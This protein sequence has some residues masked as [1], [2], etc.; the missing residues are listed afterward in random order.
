[1]NT[2]A[3]VF[4][5]AVGLAY[6]QPFGLYI[7]TQLA[8]A[9]IITHLRASLVGIPLFLGRHGRT[10]LASLGE[11]RAGLG[12]TTLRVDDIQFLRN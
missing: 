7:I 9:H 6:H 8:C 4:I 12:Y 10:R 5:Q 11:A 3:G 2:L 1:Q